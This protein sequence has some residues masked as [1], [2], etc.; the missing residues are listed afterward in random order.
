MR[1][2][3]T[4]ALLF[5]LSAWTDP[6]RGDSALPGLRNCG[7]GASPDQRQKCDDAASDQVKSRSRTTILDGGWRLVKTR[8]PGGGTEATSVMHAIDITKSDIDL[9]GLSLQC[10]RAGIEIVLIVLDSFPRSARPAVILT[11][12]NNRTEFEAS[13]IQHGEAL[14]LPQAAS[15]LAAADWQKEAELSIQ[16]EAKPNPIRGIVPISGLSGAFRA[17]SANCPMK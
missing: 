13:V 17:L 14:L 1:L 3:S 16:I 12:G 8:D 11:A 4:L 7:P 9:A 10:G 15:D 6:S 5:L 2:L